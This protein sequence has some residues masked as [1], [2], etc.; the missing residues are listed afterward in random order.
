MAAAA[1]AK[2]EMIPAIFLEGG[3]GRKIKAKRGEVIFRQ[4]EPS[5][6]VYFIAAGR[7]RLSVA[8]PVGKEATIALLGQGEL[9]GEQCLLFGR[10]TRVG[11]ACAL[12]ASDLVK[13]ELDTITKLL[14][15]DIQ[16]ANFVMKRV[17]ARLAHYE[18]ALVHQL[19]N[20]TERRLARALLHLSKYD[21]SA[22]QPAVIEHVSQEL[23]ANIVGASRSRLNGFMT[24]F[25]QLGYIDYAGTTITVKPS[26]MKVLFKYPGK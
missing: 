18:H 23:L 9:F 24:K 4:G 16:L 12:S 10:R 6:G 5:D 14:G 25:R 2:G 20:N 15:S 11:T 3:P 26:L 1:T 22:A 21:S 13:V 7:V 19:T 8:N 17:I